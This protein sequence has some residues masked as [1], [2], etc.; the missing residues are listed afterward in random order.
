M[1]QWERSELWRTLG[2]AA[3]ADILIPKATEGL[4]GVEST[5]GNVCAYDAGDLSTCDRHVSRWSKNASF[6]KETM[7]A[8]CSQSKFHWIKDAKRDEVARHAAAHG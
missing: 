3:Q 8:V 4:Q 5:A 6:L 1:T 7:L 2:H